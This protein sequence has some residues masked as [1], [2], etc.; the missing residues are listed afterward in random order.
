MN[1]I[2]KEVKE[3][4]PK[5][6]E[7]LFNTWTDPMKLKREREYDLYRKPL[8]DLYDFFDRKKIVIQINSLGSLDGYLNP[9]MFSGAIGWENQTHMDMMD[10][11]TWGFKTRLEAEIEIFKIAFKVLESKL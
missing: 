9:D 4:Y 2:Y 8:R 6:F 10:L 7:L 11:K 5:G 3:K 1:R